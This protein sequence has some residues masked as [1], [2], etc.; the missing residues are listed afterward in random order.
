MKM[1]II[2]IIMSEKSNSIFEIMILQEQLVK[3]F[4]AAIVGFQSDQF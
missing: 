3:I 2:V 4:W 1:L